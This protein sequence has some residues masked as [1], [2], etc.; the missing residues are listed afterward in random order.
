MWFRIVRTRQGARTDP[1]PVRGSDQSLHYESD[2]DWDP[3]TNISSHVP[4]TSVY[5]ERGESV[6]L[7]DDLLS[8]QAGV[9]MPDVSDIAGENIPPSAASVD[10]TNPF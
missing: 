5:S 4:A 6:R 10:G 8:R 3:L 9:T 2:L 1:F 7:R